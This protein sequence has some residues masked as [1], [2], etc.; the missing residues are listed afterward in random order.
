MLM[1]KT[2]PCSNLRVY[3]G[4]HFGQP[5]IILLAFD[6]TATTAASHITK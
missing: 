5:V 6:T 1:G 4:D 2:L 3:L